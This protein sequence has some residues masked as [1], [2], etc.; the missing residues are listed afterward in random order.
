M[1][2]GVGVWT[3]PAD[4]LVTPLGVVDGFPLG[5][6]HRSVLSFVFV[7]GCLFVRCIGGVRECFITIRISS[8]L[9]TSVIGRVRS[10]AIASFVRVGV[11]V[12]V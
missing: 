7:D 4:R 9:S 5:Q 8:A 12:Q 1:G 10:I 11:G 3:S 2:Y 6:V